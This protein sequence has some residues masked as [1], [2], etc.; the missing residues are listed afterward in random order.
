MRT[1]SP[2]SLLGKPSYDPMNEELLKKYRPR[3]FPPPNASPARTS[4]EGLV[5]LIVDATNE[6]NKPKLARALAITAKTLKWTDQDLHLLYQKR[7]DPKVRNFSAL[8]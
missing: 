2:A 5:Q 3:E 1:A 8:V 6:R 4:A 7:L